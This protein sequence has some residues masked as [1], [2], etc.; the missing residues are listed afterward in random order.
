[1]INT[2]LG[3]N[4]TAQLVLIALD[5]ILFCGCRMTEKRYGILSNRHNI[6]FS[7]LK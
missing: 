7:A 2:I 6:W 1:M 4:I 5:G 3:F